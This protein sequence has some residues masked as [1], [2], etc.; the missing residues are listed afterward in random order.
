MDWTKDYRIAWFGEFID[1]RLEDEYLAESL[2]A[3]RKITAYI[4][5]VFG[6]ILALF[7]VQSYITEGETVLFTR[8]TLIRLPFIIVSMVMFYTARNIT[9]HKNLVWMISSYQA[10]MAIT[11]LLTLKQYDSLNFF[12]IIGF[13]IVTLAMYLLPNKTVFSQFIS[14]I[15]SFLFFLYPTRK[16]EG[17]Q[18]YVFFRSVAYQAI[19]LMYCNINNCWTERVKRKAFIANRE[20]LDLSS[21]DSLTG[22]YNRKKFD[23]ALDQW[24]SFSQRYNHP[25]ALILFDIDDFKQVNDKHGHIVGDR[26]LQEISDNVKQSIREA[27][28]FARWGGDEFAILLPNTDLKQAEKLAERIKS[29]IAKHNPLT[30]PKKITCSFGVAEY[31]PNDTKQSLLR[32]TDDLLLKAKTGGKDKVVS[33]F[34]NLGS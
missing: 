22:I 29:N 7:L 25:L 6:S 23:D 15:F 2:D 9:K 10:M 32:K 19:M 21:K 3:S 17:L 16:L 34:S 27:D 1:K 30:D 33:C 5:L 20:L 31:A 28:I 11:Y 8:I 13:L 18:S 14:L 24:I 12:S 26:V 4:A